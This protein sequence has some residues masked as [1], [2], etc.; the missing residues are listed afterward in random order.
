MI[1]TI[2]KYLSGSLKAVVLA[3]VLGLSVNITLGADN[4]RDFI[5]RNNYLPGGKY[6]LFGNGRGAV[7]DL[8]GNVLSQGTIAYTAG[9][10][11][12]TITSFDGK[13]EYNQRFSNHEYWEHS[14]FSSS[15]S[16]S[17]D[18]KKGSPAAGGQTVTN[19]NIQASEVH[20]ADGYD[21]EQGGGYP[22]PT[23]ARDEYT[24]I[25]SGSVRTI[26]VV[27]PDKPQPPKSD[28]KPN[29]PYNN[30]SDN[31]NNGQAENN[32]GDNS[33]RQRELTGIGDPSVPNN[34]PELANNNNGA[35][36]LPQSEN[37][38]PCVDCCPTCPTYNYPGWQLVPV[39]QP[40]DKNIGILTSALNSNNPAAVETA[41]LILVGSSVVTQQTAD[42]IQ[43]AANRG[44]FDGAK[45]IL[46]Q[47]Q[48][49]AGGAMPPNDNGDNGQD[50][51]KN[52]K[53]TQKKIDNVLKDTNKG[54]ETKGSAHQYEKAGDFETAKQDFYSLNPKNVK[55]RSDGKI[56]G[57]LSDGRQV[58]VRIE[59][60][61]KRPT[62][63]IQNTRNNY[64]KI[65]YGGK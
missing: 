19:F 35:V 8:R 2:K 4:P 39:V 21:G 10:I 40:S 52:K 32:S 45:N 63:E 41:L 49:A 26:K 33:N 44:D 1:K 36:P 27:N 28:N 61:D 55:V 48:A 20:P 58:N 37:P 46:T 18:S 24:Y 14:P 47:S 11:H 65:R 54:R 25:V 64:T 3:S 5:N 59:S 56:T 34:S 31:G 16:R 38:Y 13:I 6:R 9:P 15:A 30:G 7:T 53:E 23:G 50:K 29:N 43:S 12:T 60:S 62:L 22:T 57:E 42:A 17:F 51:D